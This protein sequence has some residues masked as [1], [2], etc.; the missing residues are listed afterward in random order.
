MGECAEWGEGERTPSPKNRRRSRTSKSIRHLARALVLGG[1]ATSAMMVSKL[2]RKLG[3]S[4]QANRKT[5]QGSRHSDRDAQLEHINKRVGEAIAAGSSAI[6]VDTKKKEPVGNFKNGGGELEPKG[7]PTEVLVH[8]FI[9]DELGR[10]NPYG[11]YD[12]A[13]NQAWVSVGIDH[14]TG[15]FAVESVR[16]W[17]YMMG[18]PIFPAAKAILIT[19]DGGGSNGSRLRLWKVELQKLADELKM[20]ISVS[21]LPPGTSKWNKIEHRLFSF[22][23]MNWRG[24]L[25]ISHQVIVNLISATTTTTGLKVKAVIDPCIYPTGIKVTDAELAQLNIMRDGFHGEWNYTLNP[26]A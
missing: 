6:S 17:W 23:T 3:Y 1:H 11:V 8:D 7:E 25:L 24:K 18:T 15:A 13:N 21:H 9:D 2:L 10:A 12:I 14:D 26:R 19:A 5:K 16:C 22:I 4:V 20:P